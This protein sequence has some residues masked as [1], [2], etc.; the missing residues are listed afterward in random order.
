MTFKRVQWFFLGK[1][2]FPEIRSEW[3]V[4]QR[5][6]LKEVI[7]RDEPINISVDGQCD[8]PGHNATYCTVTSMDCESDK[9]LSFEVVNV[10]ECKNSQGK[11]LIFLLLTYKICELI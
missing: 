7:A 8:S 2:V 9:V 6:V 10:K 5:S 4:H 1:Y 11:K 3:K